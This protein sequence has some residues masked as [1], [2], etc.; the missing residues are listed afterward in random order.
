MDRILLAPQRVGTGFLANNRITRPVNLRPSLPDPAPASVRSTPGCGMR[1][2]R[3]RRRAP[4]GGA[5]ARGSAA[6]AAGEAGECL[7]CVKG[8]EVV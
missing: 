1:P 4:R 3:R 5:A 2:R 8:C 7:G 6:E